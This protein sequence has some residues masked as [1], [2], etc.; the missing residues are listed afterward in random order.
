MED[1][2]TQ[3]PTTAPESPA[4]DNPAPTA[5]L[6]NPTNPT[7]PTP[8]PTP[9]ATSPDR[10]RFEV[11]LEFVQ[12]LASPAYLNFL[13]QNEYFDSP[14]FV[15]YLNYLRYW[16]KPA[17]ARF[18][19][20][21]HALYFLHLLQDPTFREALKRSD[22]TMLIHQQQGYNW[23]YGKTMRLRSETVNGTP[24]LHP[25]APPS[26]AQ[27]PPAALPPSADASAPPPNNNASP[28]GIAGETNVGKQPMPKESAPVE[29]TA[30]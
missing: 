19:V 6:A 1:V 7:A 10:E 26:A 24:T 27:P 28:D 8:N 4:P 25:S 9:N 15:A 5:D 30:M 20:F 11:E 23:Q 29:G 2:P 16:K 12:C 13:A 18:I 22:Y 17:Y 3:P 14:D 21:P